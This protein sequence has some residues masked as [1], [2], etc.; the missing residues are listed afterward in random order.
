MTTLSYSVTEPALRSSRGVATSA[1]QERVD[2]EWWYVDRAWPRYGRATLFPA[3]CPCPLQWR[4]EDPA[5]AGLPRGG[6]KVVTA[7]SG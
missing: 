7:L 2:Y 1:K 6:P 4:E 3:W 5:S